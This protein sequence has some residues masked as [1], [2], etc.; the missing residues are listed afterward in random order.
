LPA[1]QKEHA[2]FHLRPSLSREYKLASQIC[3]FKMAGER[4]TSHEDKT[5]RAGHG[6][7]GSNTEMGGKNSLMRGKTNGSS[8]NKKWTR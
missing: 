7:E 4:T 3:A 5:M 2:A 6:Q 1:K 8:N